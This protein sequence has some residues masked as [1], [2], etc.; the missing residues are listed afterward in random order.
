MFTQAEPRIFL[1]VR[2]DNP[3]TLCVV[4]EGIK[5]DGSHLMRTTCLDAR[6][7]GVDCWR[8]AEDSIA[9]QLYGFPVF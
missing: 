8:N 4:T 1:F 9:E 6:V 3:P 5:A 2:M 7:G